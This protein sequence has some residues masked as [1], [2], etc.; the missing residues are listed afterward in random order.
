[1]REKTDSGD[2]ES[3]DSVNTLSREATLQFNITVALYE[4][5]AVR[6]TAGIRE[7]LPLTDPTGFEPA[8]SALTGPHVRPLHHGSNTYA[9][10]MI[11]EL[12]PFVNCQIQFF[13]AVLNAN[14][15]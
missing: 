9:R 4:R 3:A 15:A 12:R 2:T 10:R 6:G 7:F 8:I 14:K 1:M 13:A 11:P 5:F